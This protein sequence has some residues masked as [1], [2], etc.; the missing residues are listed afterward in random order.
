MHT[1]GRN[2]WTALQ[3]RHGAQGLRR[4]GFLVLQFTRF[5]GTKVQILTPEE[6]GLPRGG[7]LVPQC[8]CFTG[9]NVQ[10]LT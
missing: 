10:I 3:K 8:T 1:D 4:R 5:T 7:C 6:Q 9:T 2:T